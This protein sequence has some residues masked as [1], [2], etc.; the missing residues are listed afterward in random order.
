MVKLRWAVE[1]RALLLEERDELPLAFQ[2]HGHV[3][4]EGVVLDDHDSGC[5]LGALRLQHVLEI[6]FAHMDRRGGAA[7]TGVGKRGVDGRGACA[8]GR[9]RDER[10]MRPAQVE[11]W[12]KREYAVRLRGVK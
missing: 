9:I 11:L 2:V 10:A 6:A 3:M 12:P 4:V 5:I 8:L 1:S 7:A